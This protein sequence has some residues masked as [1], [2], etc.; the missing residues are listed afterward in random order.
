MKGFVNSLFVFVYAVLFSLM[1][2]EVE[3]KYGWCE[4]L[5]TPK[6]IGNFTIYHC[7]M[8]MIVIITLLYAFRHNL[9][10]AIFYITAWFLIEDFMWFVLNPHYTLKHYKKEN[11]WWHARSRWHFGIPEHN[12]IGVGLIVLAYILS[13]NR[14]ELNLA[15]IS[16][17]VFSFFIISVSDYYHSFYNKTHECFKSD[18]DSDK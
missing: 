16:F 5:P 11:I 3:G 17:I 6:F 7:I 4:K 18:L 15:I 2:I 10:L 9:I 14:N 1:E 8:N 13:G 12:F